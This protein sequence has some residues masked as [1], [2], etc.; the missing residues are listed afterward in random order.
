MDTCFSWCGDQIRELTRYKL[1]A[2]LTDSLELRYTTD[3]GTCK[4]ALT[5]SEAETNA[6][7]EAMTE[8]DRQLEDA[9]H[10]LKVEQRKR[11]ITGILGGLGIILT[12]ILCN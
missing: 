9:Y 8:Q 10:K 7:R 3:M 6:I 11:K 1:K 5:L 2:V 4:D 12:L